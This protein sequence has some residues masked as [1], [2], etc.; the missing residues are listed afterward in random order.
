MM[1]KLS[2]N[3]KS[4]R[5]KH[6]LSQTEFATRLH[7]TKQAVSKWETDRGYP[8]SSLIPVIAKEL[9]I[10][11]DSLMGETR[12]NRRKIIII[13]LVSVLFIILI[14]LTPLIVNYYHEIQ[15]FNDFKENIENIT[16]L[17]LPDTGSL[18]YTDFE[19]WIIYGNTVPINQMS[20]LVFNDSNQTG[21]F[22]TN[23]ETDS[24]WV[25]TL[26]SDF[27][28]LIPANIK[29]YASIGDYYLIY[30]I[31][32]N[33]YNESII[34]DGSYDLLFLIYQIDNNRLIV[35]E[36]SFYIEGGE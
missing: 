25:E 11:I 32:T 31:G 7:V 21:L 28:D 1:G 8:D 30:N 12:N 20:Y 3:I 19:D 17:D 14:V 18:V 15:E 9:G 33:T 34:E 16:D 22:E 4:Y 6:S 5:K 2:E 29:D 36:Y 26:S 13:S 10:T 27:L 24:R 35:F 23:L